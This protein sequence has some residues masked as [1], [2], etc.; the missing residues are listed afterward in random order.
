[1]LGLSNYVNAHIRKFYPDLP[2]DRLLRL[3]NAVDLD[4]FDPPPP[5][6]EPSTRKEVRGL[7]IANDFERKGVPQAIKAVEMVNDRRLNI[8]IVGRG[9]I[10]PYD[11]ATH[12][13]IGVWGEVADPRERYRAAD[14]FVLPTRHDPCSLVVL[15]A[16]AMGLPVISTRFNG[17]TEIM[18]DGVHGY[19]LDDPDDIPALADAMRK[20]LDPERRAQMSLACRALR[21]QLSYAHHLDRLEAIYEQIQS[22]RS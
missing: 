20:M 9:N 16:L 6:L 11:H 15:E 12:W 22:D 5:P 1:V 7:I 18:T 3:F 4:R 8:D 14:F 21:P 19:I 13:P 10:T 2:D 17:A